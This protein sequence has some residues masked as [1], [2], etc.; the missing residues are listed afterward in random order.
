VSDADRDRAISELSDAFQAGRLTADEFEERSGEALRARTGKDIARL[1][2]DLPRNPALAPAG[3][4]EPAPR[5]PG[6]A[7]VPRIMLAV[8]VIV[9]LVIAAIASGQHGHHHAFGVLPA[10]AALLFIARLARGAD[11][12]HR[13]R[14]F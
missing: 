13:G 12:H 2:A 1:L 7:V 6:F 3:P 11:H 4:A 9:L 8:P 5:S 10:L 14:R